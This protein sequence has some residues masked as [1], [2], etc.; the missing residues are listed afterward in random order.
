MD[1]MHSLLASDNLKGIRI[2]DSQVVSFRLFVDDVGMFTPTTL[3]AFQEAQAAIQTYK[4]ALDSKLNLQK[5][6]IIPF[7]I[8]HSTPWLET[9]AA[10]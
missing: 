3:E 8:T 9:Q 10:S 2:S 4:L 7:N 5:S 6:T 1:H